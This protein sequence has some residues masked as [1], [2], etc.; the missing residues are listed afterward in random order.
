MTPERQNAGIQRELRALFGLGIL[1]EAQY[2][3]LA[4]R[5]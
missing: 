1:T 4:A 2:T 3:E 5:Q